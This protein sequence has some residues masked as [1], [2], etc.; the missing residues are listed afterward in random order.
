VNLDDFLERC[1]SVHPSGSGYD[2]ECPAHS[3]RNASLSVAEG[4][5]GR[6]LLHCQ[7]GCNTSD[8]MGAMGLTLR[9]LFPGSTVFG[10]PEFIYVYVDEEGVPLF[11]A[12]RMP[13]KKFRQRHYDPDHP[14]SKDGWVWN[15]EDRD[16]NP[17]RRVLYRLPELIFGLTEGRGVY[18]VEGEKDVESLR[19]LGYVGTCNPMGAG[20]WRDEYSPIFTGANVTIVAD[21]DDA[22]RAHANR[23]LDS[24]KPYAANIR[25]MQAKEGKDITDHLEAGLALVELVPIRQGPRRGI[26]TAQQMAEAA[27]EILVKTEFDTPGYEMLEGTPVKFRQGRMYALGAY[28]SDGKTCFAVQVARKLCTAG[29]R[30]GYYSLEMPEADLRNKL[31]QHRGVPLTLLEEPWVLRQNPAMLDLF[32]AAVD[33]MADWHLDIV[34][35]TKVSADYV[36]QTSNER[37]HDFVIID[38]IHRFGWGGERRALE[39]EVQKLTNLALE[40]NI[41]LFLLCQLRK[42]QRGQNMVAYPRPTLQEFRETSIIGDDSSIAMALW[43]TRDDAGMKFMGGTDL[44]ILKNRHT[45]GPDDAGGKMFLPDFDLNTQLFSIRKGAHEQGS[46]AE[47]NVSD[48]E[49]S[50]DGGISPSTWGSLFD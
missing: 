20:K 38:H 6:L 39:S 42:T 10:E 19:A 27:R 11:Q 34:F 8:I 47:S 12:V 24:V 18:I 29:V 7:A 21:R 32:H 35:N 2:V 28:T 43:R 49:E 23:V 37:E 40:S 1:A 41:P 22:G 14:D 46:R 50:D 9:D 13:G 17:L 31:I 16:G 45:T 30:V 48:G 44:T 5:D 36:V 25:I 26:V 15:L 3:D 33:E 4:E